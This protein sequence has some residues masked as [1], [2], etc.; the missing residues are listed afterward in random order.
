MQTRLE[1]ARTGAGGSD[2]DGAARPQAVCV[3]RAGAR[4][5]GAANG[6]PG[7][8]L[9]AEWGFGWHRNVDIR[10]SCAS[11]QAQV[12]TTPWA[13]VSTQQPLRRRASNPSWPDGG[14][15]SAVHGA[16]P[17]IMP[18]CRQMLDC[19]LD[20]T[21]PGNGG[22]D[23]KRFARPRSCGTA[24][25][26]ETSHDHPLVGRWHGTEREEQRRHGSSETGGSYRLHSPERAAYLLPQPDGDCEQDVR[27]SRLAVACKRLISTLAGKGRGLVCIMVASR[28]AGMQGMGSIVRQVLLSADAFVAACLAVEMHIA[29][30]PGRLRGPFS[31]S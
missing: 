19:P 29:E 24:G 9:H 11:Q 5:P 17:V 1:A 30:A 15:C 25:L 18:A 27:L 3:I 4:W 13:G 22:R 10:I 14:A 23:P 20:E 8:L 6:R 16:E 7:S 21:A 12:G 31:I 28:Q 2:A 26:H